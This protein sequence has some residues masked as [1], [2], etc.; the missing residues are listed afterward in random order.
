LAFALQPVDPRSRV[1]APPFDPVHHAGAR[2]D[3]ARFTPAR[4][5]PP[6]IAMRPRA[7]ARSLMSGAWWRRRQA[8][9]DAKRS[10]TPRKR[11][12]RW[13][14]PSCHA[15]WPPTSSS[16]SSVGLRVPGRAFDADGPFERWRGATA[17]ALFTS[18]YQSPPTA[19]MRPRLAARSPMSG[20]SWRA[21][22]AAT[23]GR[24]TLIQSSGAMPMCHRSPYF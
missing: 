6:S 2:T 24:E 9:A 3:N 19:A 8:R 1:A 11:F 13:R 22:R 14:A 10:S 23:C 16:R 17:A 4:S 21:T 18:A 12:E 15:A 20:G 7:A 5:S